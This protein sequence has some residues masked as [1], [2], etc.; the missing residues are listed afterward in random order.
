MAK[1]KVV[2]VEKMTKKKRKEYYSKKRGVN[3]FNTG[4]RTMK[5]EKNPSRS[6]EKRKLRKEIEKNA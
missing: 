6:E 2:E 5:T 4:T 3:G 1:R